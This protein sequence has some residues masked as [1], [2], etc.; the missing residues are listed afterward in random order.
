VNR[1]DKARLTRRAIAAYGIATMREGGGDV[2]YSGALMAMLL[3]TGSGNALAQHSP[4]PGGGMNSPA[5]PEG[6]ITGYMSQG[7]VTGL[8]DFVDSTRRLEPKDL[9]SKTQATKRSTVMLKAL[10]IDCQLTDARHVAS[11]KATAGGQPVD[12]G[13]YEIAC[14]NGMGY[15]LTLMGLASASGI[16]CFA[17]SATQQGDVSDPAKVDLKCRLPANESLNT[18]ATKVMRN[19]GAM[20]DARDLKWLGQSAEPKVDYTE[21]ACT[22][23]QGVVLRTPTPGSNGKIDVLSCKDAAARGAQCQMS[24]TAPATAA[25]AA[26][27]IAGASASAAEPRPDL[28]WFKDALK[29]N[30]VSCEVKKARIVGRES[31]KR[32]YIVE[33]QCPQQPRG[34]VAY[35]PSG[36]DAVNPFESI[37][38]DAAAVRKI[39]CQF[40]EVH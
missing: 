17:A 20:C 38:C 40:V 24:G 5:N 39:A 11:G 29:N 12:V 36:G 1:R 25:A 4:P 6:H 18:M 14:G 35:V 33:Y 37:D 27:P 15:L 9:V 30:G 21:I 22:D 13:L 7:D 32:R 16:S 31:I 3:M 2:R 8:A 19:A 26:T 10:Q 34:L 23:G 28:Q